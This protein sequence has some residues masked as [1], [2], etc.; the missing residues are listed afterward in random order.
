[1]IAAGIVTFSD[2]TQILQPLESAD[3]I[4][5]AAV[6]VLSPV[7][8]VSVGVKLR[9]SRGVRVNVSVEGGVW[10]CECEDEMSVILAL[11]T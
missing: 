4:N 8:F 5:W 2:D 10:K 11:C 9:M 6:K 3:K 1:M 7:F